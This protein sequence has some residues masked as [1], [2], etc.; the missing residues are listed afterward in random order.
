MRGTMRQLIPTA[1]F[2]AALCLAS[3]L[4]TVAAQGVTATARPPSPNSADD[5]R[6]LRATIDDLIQRV[7]ELEK[8]RLEILK[9]KEAEAAERRAE[10]A[11]SA[12]LEQ[13]L[14]SLEKAMQAESA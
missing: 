1:L 8:Q 9:D 14:A 12:R 4:Q 10:E 2:G 5:A 7:Q 13:R 11:K 6:R 3:S